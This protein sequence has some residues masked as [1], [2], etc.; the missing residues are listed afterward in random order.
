MTPSS[1]SDTVTFIGGPTI[2]G[3][4]VVVLVVVVDVVVVVVDVVVVLVDVVVVVGGAGVQESSANVTVHVP[5]GTG[6]PSS[7]F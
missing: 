3:S 2:G 1:V 7:K 5:A 4:V 6:S